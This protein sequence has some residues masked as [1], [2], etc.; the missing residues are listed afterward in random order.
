MKQFMRPVFQYMCRLVHVFPFP[1]MYSSWTLACIVGAYKLYSHSFT[2]II[3][4]LAADHTAY[5][6]WQTNF[7]CN[8]FLHNTLPQILV[9][10]VVVVTQTEI[11]HVL[12]AVAQSRSLPSAHDESC[13]QSHDESCDLNQSSPR[14]WSCV[15]QL[16]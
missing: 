13:D 11:K 14:G 16:D 15:R 2:I 8:T 5:V 1:C 9:S 10:Q 3:P 7:Q 12:L 4:S 6:N